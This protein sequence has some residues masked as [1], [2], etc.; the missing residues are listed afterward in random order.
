MKNTHYIMKINHSYKEIASFKKC[1]NKINWNTFNNILTTNLAFTF[2]MNIIV[3]LFDEYFRHKPLKLTR[4]SEIK[5]RDKLI[6]QSKKH[7]TQPN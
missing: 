6:V 7:P 4:K 2:F 5:V 3:D 1:V